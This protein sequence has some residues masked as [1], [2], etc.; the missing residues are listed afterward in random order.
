MSSNTPA[1]DYNVAIDESLKAEIERA[2][3]KLNQREVDIVKMFF[4]L[5]PYPVS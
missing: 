2:L 4:G 1:T 5:A 3:A